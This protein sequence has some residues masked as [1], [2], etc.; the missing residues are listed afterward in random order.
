MPKRKKKKNRGLFIW[1]FAFFL[2]NWGW[3]LQQQ[4]FRGIF[5]G[6]IFRAM[7]HSFFCCFLQYILDFLIGFNSK[8][9]T[10]NF[11]LPFFLGSHK[12]F[13]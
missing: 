8:V 13:G 4:I 2:F 3:F 12:L 10:I 9:F 7:N 5:L 11:I 6:N 1:P